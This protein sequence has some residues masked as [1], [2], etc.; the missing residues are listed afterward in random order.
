MPYWVVRTDFKLTYLQNSLIR[1]FLFVIHQI[2]SKIHVLGKTFLDNKQNSRHFWRKYA[3][4]F[5]VG[6]YLLLKAYR[7]PRATL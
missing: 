3:R 1:V 5:V 4:M 7:I 6:H 2:F